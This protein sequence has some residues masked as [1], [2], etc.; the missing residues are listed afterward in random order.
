MSEWYVYFLATCRHHLGP[1]VW[2]VPLESWLPEPTLFP[3]IWFHLNSF[4]PSP[5]ETP[6]QVF[7]CEYC[8]IFKS[9]FF[10]E[11]RLTATSVVFSLN[12]IRVWKNHSQ[13]PFC[14]CTHESCEH[15]LS[16]IIRTLLELQI[17]WKSIFGNLR[18]HFDSPILYEPSFAI[19]KENI[20][21]PPLYS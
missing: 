15:V 17:L 20:I 13:F 21:K 14:D 9:T 16:Y 11:H 2:E 12:F 1:Y 4:T 5:L 19:F 18:M 6:T 7:S 3:L 8:E 10:E